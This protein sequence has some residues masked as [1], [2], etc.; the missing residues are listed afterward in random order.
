[1]FELK[2]PTLPYVLPVQV[3]TVL[4]QVLGILE[5]KTKGS[6][7][8]QHCYD[9]AFLSASENYILRPLHVTMYSECKAIKCTNHPNP[10]QRGDEKDLSQTYPH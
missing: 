1:M 8:S 10:Q 5:G 7:S 2:S 9:T 6:L 4:A 3:L